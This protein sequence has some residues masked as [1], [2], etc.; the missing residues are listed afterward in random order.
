MTIVSFEHNFIFVKTQ[1][2]AG[3]SIEIELSKCVEEDAIV[4]PIWPPVAGHRPRN[5]QGSSVRGRFENHMSA[6]LIKGYL[7]DK[8]FN[9]MFKFCVEREPVSKCLSH[10][11]M[12]RNSP[13]HNM[14]GQYQKTWLQYCDEKQFPIDTG[15][16]G[17]IKN[18]KISKIVDAIIPY[19]ELNTSLCQIMETL[20]IKGFKLEATAKSE[21][22][23][24]RI[25]SYDDVEQKQRD[26]IYATFE[27]SL[28]VSELKK[29][30]EGPN[31]VSKTSSCTEPQKI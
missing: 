8:T 4:T 31:S 15:K 7:G 29:Y 10:F 22:S 17:E 20:S 5:F 14:L 24:K 1:K 23:K 28:S 9:R 11:H 25:L 26:I 3:T 13:F 19:E 30:Y 21:Y 27:E 16:Y 12:L 18:G 2:A 6:S